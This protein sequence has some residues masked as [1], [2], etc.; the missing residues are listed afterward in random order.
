M[1]LNPYF[2]TL[3]ILLFKVPLQVQENTLE[4]TYPTNALRTIP[5]PSNSEIRIP[6][7]NT[8]PEETSNVVM[9]AAKKIK[10]EIEQ[11]EFSENVFNEA[12][13]NNTPVQNVGMRTRSSPI[14]AYNAIVSY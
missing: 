5:V 11:T 13:G 1:N 12:R 2:L 14:K 7:N 9:R 3:I 6:S 8:L 10:T 4:T